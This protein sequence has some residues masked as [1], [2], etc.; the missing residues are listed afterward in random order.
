MPLHNG[1]VEGFVSVA[2]HSIY[3]AKLV[4]DKGGSSAWEG[5]A[6]SAVVGQGLMHDAA[7]AYLG[8]LVMP[9]K[10]LP[11]VEAV[12]GPIEANMDRVICERFGMAQTVR[13]RP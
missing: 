9:L 7:E 10:H 3:V 6:L 5:E 2:E 11:Q 12:F 4:Y 8:D 13:P 1:H